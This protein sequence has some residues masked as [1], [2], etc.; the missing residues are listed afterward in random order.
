MSFKQFINSI[1]TSPLG[2]L[3]CILNSPPKPHAFV[4]L[5]LISGISGT[6]LTI[7]VSVTFLRII[8][9]IVFMCSIYS[10]SIVP[11]ENVAGLVTDNA[12][13]LVG[14]LRYPQGIQLPNG[15]TIYHAIPH[16]SNLAAIPGSPARIMEYAASF[17]HLASLLSLHDTFSFLSYSYMYVIDFSNNSP[18]PPIGVDINS[19]DFFCRQLLQQ[20]PQHTDT[21]TSLMVRVNEYIDIRNTRDMGQMPNIMECQNLIEQILRQSEILINRIT[22][23]SFS[24]EFPSIEHENSSEL[25]KFYCFRMYRYFMHN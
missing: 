1:I 18:L 15:I 21:I 19:L 7:G 8:P 9:L 25:I 5:P 3:V 13:P 10:R 16:I 20:Y 22:P 14:G 17:P 12:L 23:H 6:S 24:F 2:Q 4:S 11:D